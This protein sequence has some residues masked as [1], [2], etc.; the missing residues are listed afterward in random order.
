MKTASTLFV[1]VAIT[2]SSAF[3]LGWSK[4]SAAATPLPASSDLSANQSSL[5]QQIVSKEREGLDALK[6]GNVELFGNLTA[7]DAVF[8]DA[9]GPA[10]KAEVLKHVAGFKLVDYSMDDVRFV[11]LSAKSG[12]ITYKINEKGFS[13]GREFS[14]LVYVSAL[15]TK[16]GS[17]WVCVFSQETAAK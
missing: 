2:I 11:R 6:T 5:E 17:K 10:S 9:H 4:T 3:L 8:V 15:W 12:L 1:V 7:E 14:A 16:R 13:H